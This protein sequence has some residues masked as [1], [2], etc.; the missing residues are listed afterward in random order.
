MPL[1]VE[2]LGMLIYGGVASLSFIIISF[3]AHIRLH[4][5]VKQTPADVSVSSKIH[6]YRETTP[7][8]NVNISQELTLDSL[9]LHR[10]R[11]NFGNTNSNDSSP[12]IA[13]SYPFNCQYWNKQTPR[14][15][16]CNEDE[17]EQCSISKLQN[18]KLLSDFTSTI[19]LLFDKSVPLTENSK[20]CTNKA[21]E[22]FA[23]DLLLSAPMTERGDTKRTISETDVLQN[24]FG[25]DDI[26]P[27]YPTYSYSNV[28]LA[29]YDII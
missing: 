4:S 22:I 20:S 23:N 9:N 17:M 6:H 7:V 1:A 3:I 12:T 28:L 29:R 2:T 13:E 10:K 8:P 21:N 25:N 19:L 27:L 11:T 18:N 5:T 15:M 16:D 24:E 26:V 14:I